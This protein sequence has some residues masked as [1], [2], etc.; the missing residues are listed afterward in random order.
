MSVKGTFTLSKEERICSKKL[1]EQLFNGGTARS[2]SSFPLRVVFTTVER[3]PGQPPANIIVSVPKRHFKHAVDRNRVKRQLREAYRH[4]KQLLVEAVADT[5][6]KAIALSLI[7]MDGRHLPSSEI[8]HKLQ[9]LLTR[10][11]SQ[12]S[13]TPASS[14]S[15][16]PDCSTPASPD[17]T[18]AN[19]VCCDSFATSP[20]VT[21]QDAPNGKVESLNGSML[22]ECLAR[23]FRTSGREAARGRRIG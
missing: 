7:W 11:A 8:D 5:P 10:I 9:N 16:S 4:H 19:P 13:A 6:Q 17:S 23:I 1:M 21:T 20:R 12:L 3:Q 22:Q 15:A 18:S 14:S 2:M